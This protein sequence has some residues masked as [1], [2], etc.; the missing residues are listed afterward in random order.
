MNFEIQIDC[1]GHVHEPIHFDIIDE[2]SLIDTRLH[3]RHVGRL[4]TARWFRLNNPDVRVCCTLIMLVWICIICTSTTTMLHPKARPRLTETGQTKKHHRNP[5]APPVRP[6]AVSARCRV[7]HWRCI[8]RIEGAAAGTV[9]STPWIS[10]TLCYEPLPEARSDLTPYRSLCTSWL[11]LKAWPSRLWH[12]A[13]LRNKA[14]PRGDRS[15]TWIAA[16][17][18]LPRLWP[19]LCSC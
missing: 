19:H 11:L 3:L 5:R 16:S 12:A 7:P 13:S 17:T 4:V 6:P 9:F 14:C 10:S 8:C 15:N 1:K 18:P 2:Q